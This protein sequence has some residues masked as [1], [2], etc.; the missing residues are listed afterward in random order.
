MTFSSATACGYAGLMVLWRCWRQSASG[1]GQK[2]VQYFRTLTFLDITLLLVVV[3]WMLAAFMDMNGGRYGRIS[4]D[5]WN[6]PDAWAAFY[7]VLSRMS[8]PV[9][10][11]TAVLGG[12]ALLRMGWKFF[13]GRWDERDGK[14]FLIY[15][16]CGICAVGMAVFAV[17]VGART[18]PQCGAIHAAYGAF[19]FQVL[20]I[21]LS[22]AY[23]LL[24]MPRLRFFAPAVV[25]LLLVDASNAERPWARYYATAANRQLMEHWVRE[26]QAAD[27]AGKDSVELPVPVLAWPHPQEMGEKLAQTL[28]AHGVT[29]RRLRITLREA[30]PPDGIKK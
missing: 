10:A 23:L 3:F 27:R 5:G 2:C 30:V 18:E 22:A 12:G 21:S 25:A 26:A 1:L 8:I 16:A 13:G 17:A 24:D 15:C 19:F 11:A 7:L 14:F 20:G 29:E 6:F 9:M 28:F 4:K